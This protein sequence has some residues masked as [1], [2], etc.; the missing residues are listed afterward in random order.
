MKNG[1]AVYSKMTISKKIKV[2][3]KGDRRVLN[4]GEQNEAYSQM[5]N[6]AYELLI[7][8]VKE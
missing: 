7:G 3:E 6:A 1:K 4:N 8:M 2:R 5:I